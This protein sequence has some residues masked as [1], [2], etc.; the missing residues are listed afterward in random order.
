MTE[1]F[2]GTTPKRVVLLALA[3][4]RRRL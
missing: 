3:G 2:G 1:N 4:A